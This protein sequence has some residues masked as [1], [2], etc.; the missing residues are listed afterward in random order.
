[1][2][3]GVVPRIY[4]WPSISLITEQLLSHWGRVTHICIDKLSI[5]GPDNGLSPGRH[6]AI[7]W[8]NTGILLIRTL[9]TNFG[10]ILNEKFMHI[11]SRKCIW[12][13]CLGNSVHFV[14]ALKCCVSHY[15]WINYITSSG[16]HRDVIV[17]PTVW[18]KKRAHGWH[19][20][21]FCC[22]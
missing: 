2:P 8:T 20:V 1:M 19:F 4:S 15:S 16:W 13:Y 21:E 18:P 7:I 10:E 11:H 12:K 3:Y 5:I 17:M 22:S 14:L 6:E 9:G